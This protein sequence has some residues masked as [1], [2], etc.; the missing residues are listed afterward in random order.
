MKKVTYLLILCLS[1]LFSFRNADK[2]SERNAKIIHELNEREIPEGNKVI[3]LVG[4]TLID[5]K[6]GEPLTNARVVI[7]NNRIEFA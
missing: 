1:L 3:A 6:G 2:S 5:G 4:A 7:K